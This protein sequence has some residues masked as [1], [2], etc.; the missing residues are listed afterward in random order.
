MSSHS[1]AE[2]SV[3]HYVGRNDFEA[4][5][6]DCGSILDSHPIDTDGKNQV[7]W[8][9][10]QGRHCRLAS[11]VSRYKHHIAWPDHYYGEVKYAFR[12]SDPTD[13]TERN[14]LI[15]GKTKSIRQYNEHMR[16]L[17]AEQHL[18]QKALIKSILES[19]DAFEYPRIMS[20]SEE[21]TFTEIVD[22]YRADTVL[23]RFG[24]VIGK[25]FAQTNADPHT[26]W[27]I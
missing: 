6:W 25:I 14:Y 19:Y 16:I 22:H 20:D 3:G 24:R 10:E 13:G 4:M 7:E 5:L 18:A 27:Y 12:R 1:D 15:A 23:R 17:P 21:T 11:K 2:R 26:S 9:D 8:T